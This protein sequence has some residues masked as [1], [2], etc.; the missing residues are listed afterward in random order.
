MLYIVQFEDKPNMGELRDKLFAAHK[1][2]LDDSKDRVLIPGSIPKLRCDSEPAGSKLK[3]PFCATC[4]PRKEGRVTKSRNLL[5]HASE[6]PPED[7]GV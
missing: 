2:F 6:T 4:A 7:G 1:Q 5:V 3:D